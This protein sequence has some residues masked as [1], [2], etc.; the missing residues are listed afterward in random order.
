M[1]IRR[2][3]MLLAVPPFLLL[4]LANALLLYWHEKTEVEAG[5][6][7][8]ALAV[9]VTTAEFVRGIDDAATTLALP[10]RAAALRSAAA[11]IPDLA[12]LHLVTDGRPLALGGQMV[13]AVPD[14]SPP[15]RPIV[16]ARSAQ[17]RAMVIALAPVA[18]GTYVAASIDARPASE[19]LSQSVL[20]IILFTLAAAAVGIVL[21]ALIATGITRALARTER[22]ISAARSG[23]RPPLE[24]SFQVREIREL[25]EA[26]AMMGANARAA[27]DRLADSH[28]RRQPDEIQAVAAIR[29]DWLA[30]LEATAAG[31]TISVRLLG[32]ASPG[33][34]FVL[35]QRG[36]G[37]LL[38][39]GECAGVNPHDAL[40]NAMAARGYLEAKLLRLSTED[41]IAQARRGYRLKHVQWL[42]W[43]SADARRSFGDGVK[44]LTLLEP[45]HSSQVDAY[46]AKLPG[47]STD[48][49][50]GD[51]T[52]LLPPA[53]NGIVAGLRA[54]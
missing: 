10:H 9:A 16:L 32:E 34:F 19:R 35:A 3:I 49:M 31:V 26:I 39:L 18:P 12:G 29:G 47:L 15:S 41:C 11:T 4:A 6:R 2:T 46:A 20:I 48:E 14:F 22:V 43:T 40:A 13:E 51:V 7:N 25:S 45:E 24:G 8:Q 23:G 33:C 17:N 5:L 27:R 1:T 21:S 44:P 37:A 38:L 28:G 42:A 50:V 36:E 30:P 52:L 54:A 53:A